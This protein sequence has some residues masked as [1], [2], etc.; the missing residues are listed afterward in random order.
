MTTPQPDLSVDDAVKAS[1]RA[2]S[3]LF[4]TIDKYVSTEGAAPVY[5]AITDYVRAD[6]QRVMA[7]IRHTHLN[8]KTGE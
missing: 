2:M 7:L 1:N 4:A 6:H 3:H 5:R 8:P